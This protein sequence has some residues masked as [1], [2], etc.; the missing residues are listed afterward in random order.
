LREG[1]TF[2]G[3]EVFAINAMLHVRTVPVGLDVGNA[4]SPPQA[5]VTEL[6]RAP[7]PPRSFFVPHVL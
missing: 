2:L 1:D 5:R 3:G 4:R 7:G 6:P